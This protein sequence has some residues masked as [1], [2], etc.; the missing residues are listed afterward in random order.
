MVLPTEAYLEVR[1]APL[2]AVDTV[3]FDGH[4]ASVKTLWFS[5][6]FHGATWPT[7]PAIE[8]GVE[9]AFLV[10]SEEFESPTF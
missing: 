7:T 10:H 9:L 2:V 5:R 6:C 1:L 4:L 3:G 8:S